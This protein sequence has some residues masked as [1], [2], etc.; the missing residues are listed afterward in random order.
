MQKVPEACRAK[1]VIQSQV[2]TTCTTQPACFLCCEAA[3][4][5]ASLCLE[6]PEP[7]CTAC[8]WP[9]LPW[10]PSCW[11]CSSW[12]CRILPLNRVS[13]L[14]A[15]WGCAGCCCHLTELPRTTFTHSELFSR[16]HG[17]V[18]WEL[19]PGLQHGGGPWYGR[20]SGKQDRSERQ[21]SAR[22]SSAL[23]C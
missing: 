14:C 4:E 6:H 16:C 7:C 17:H 21:Q 2:S 15:W 18:C 1:Q 13:V 23:S 10:L 19:S 3:P 12:P 20:H 22:E 5:R 11:R 9:S 8:L